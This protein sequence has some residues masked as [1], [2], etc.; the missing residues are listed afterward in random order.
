MGEYTVANG[1]GKTL[2]SA[3]YDIFTATNFMVGVISAI[4][5]YLVFEY[6]RRKS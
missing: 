4:I 2:A 6:L 1:H 3:L 5:G